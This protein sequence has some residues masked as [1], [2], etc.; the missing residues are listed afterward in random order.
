MINSNPFEQEKGN[1]VNFPNPIE[2]QNIQD[3]K[4]PL[5]PL[6]DVSGGAGSTM[7]PIVASATAAAAAS[8]AIP[9]DPGAKEREESAFADK[10]IEQLDSGELLACDVQDRFIDNKVG[11]KHSLNALAKSSYY[12]RYDYQVY[13]SVGPFHRFRRPHFN[14]F[15]MGPQYVMAATPKGQDKSIARQLKR[16]QAKGIVSPDSSRASSPERPTS[17][18]IRELEPSGSNLAV[19][20]GSTKK[21]KEQYLKLQKRGG[22]NSEV[23]AKREGPMVGEALQDE[24]H[25]Q[26]SQVEA[27]PPTSNGE[28]QPPWVF[29]RSLPSGTYQLIDPG[30]IQYTNSST[31]NPMIYQAALIV[32]VLG[33]RYLV[34]SLVQSIRD[35]KTPKYKE[36]VLWLYEE[37]MISSLD[38]MRMLK[39]KWMLNDSQIFK[40]LGRANRRVKLE[41]ASKWYDHQFFFVNR[42]NQAKLKAA[43]N[44]LS[45][46]DPR[47]AYARVGLLCFLLFVFPTVALLALVEQKVH[48]SWASRELDSISQ[49]WQVTNI[50]NKVVDIRKP[51]EKRSDEP[52]QSEEVKEPGQKDKESE[53]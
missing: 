24:N 28:G 7:V 29:S 33:V 3:V 11:I 19:R 23:Q 6:F 5:N 20:S 50:E 42:R 18:E 48:D 35:L 44:S 25:N 22:G 37:N 53:S 43:T 34:I 30:T 47:F 40:F 17:G 9:G 46:T 16:F 15:G 41:P 10:T 49:G 12:N 38:A 39:H 14:Q 8:R 31:I 21:A 1:N 32:V 51:I 45:L 13:Q 2:N 27:V 26:I 52:N 36:S 4:Q